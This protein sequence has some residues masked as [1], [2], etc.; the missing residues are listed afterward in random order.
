ME[1]E[2][3]CQLDRTV[4]SLTNNEDKDKREA[5]WRSDCDPTSLC[6][7][8]ER[9]FSWRER[10]MAA[11]GCVPSC[12]RINYVLQEATTTRTR[13]EEYMAVFPEARNV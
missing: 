6:S 4:S 8:M 9:Q 10:D 3:G 11:A 2:A 1:S 7:A 13:T 12:R 5:L